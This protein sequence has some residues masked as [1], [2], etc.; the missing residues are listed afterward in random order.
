MT[1]EDRISR[2]LAIVAIAFSLLV[3][4]VVTVDAGSIFSDIVPAC[5]NPSSGNG[6]TGC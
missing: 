2:T 4:A 3:P 1:L 5:L 6:G